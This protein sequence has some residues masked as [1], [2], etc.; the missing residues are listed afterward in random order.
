M[1]MVREPARTWKNILALLSFTRATTVAVTKPELTIMVHPVV[2]ASL[3]MLM[4]SGSPVMKDN[5]PNTMNRTRNGDAMYP[6]VVAVM[7]SL[8]KGLRPLPNR[9]HLL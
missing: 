9:S 3:P 6:T 5:V 1:P 8:W 7:L 2:W 4:K